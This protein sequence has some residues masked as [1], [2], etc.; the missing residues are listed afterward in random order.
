MPQQSTNLAM[1]FLVASQAQKH[2]TH[3]EALQNLDAMVQLSVIERTLTTPPGSPSEGDR[4]LPAAGSTGEWS[5]KDGQIAAYQGGAWLFYSPQAGWRCWDENGAALYI[6]TG[7]DWDLLSSASGMTH[8]SNASPFGATNKFHLLEEELTLSGASVDSTIQIPNRAIVFAISVRTTLAVS[9]ASSYDCGIVGETSKYGG[10]LS[11]SLGTTNSG[12]TG[13]TAFYADTAIRL[14]A[15]GSN[16]SGGKVRITIHYMR[17]D[18]A[19]T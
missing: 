4:Y 17:C 6:Y 10:T 1:P 18:A 15:N 3:N 8:T 13:P 7:A 16:F 9:G 14:T 19:T 2:I 5:G 12:V 11:I